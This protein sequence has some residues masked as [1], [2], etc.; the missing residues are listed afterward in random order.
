MAVKAAHPVRPGDEIRV[1]VNG[2]DRK[3]IVQQAITK[4]VGA[5]V[6]V[7]CYLD[8]SPA[9]PAPE[10][11]ASIPQRDRGAGRPTKQERRA[12]DRMRG[13]SAP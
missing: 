4:R 5:Q 8:Q 12:L 3:V 13:L 6:A 2:V 1:R 11:L 10:V 9:P 7:Q